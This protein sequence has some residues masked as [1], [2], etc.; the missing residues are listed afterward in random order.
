MN[1]NYIEKIS[2]FHPRQQRCFYQLFA[3]FLTVSMRGILFS[4]GVPDEERIDRAK[5]INEIAHR[6]TYK[7]FSLDNTP[8]AK[9]TDAEIWAI[10]KKI[11]EKHPVET[12]LEYALNLAYDYVIENHSDDF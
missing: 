6:I 4:E 12:D 5:G 7:V 10:I 2:A 3:S 11:L 1:F 9:T 8:S